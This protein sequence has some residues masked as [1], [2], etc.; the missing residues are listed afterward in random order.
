ML[1]H[2]RFAVALA[3]ALL[4]SLTLLAQAPAPAR[5]ATSS[6]GP[7]ASDGVSPRRASTFLVE[8]SSSRMCARGTTTGAVTPN[9]AYSGGS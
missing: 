1:P 9:A 4:I 8:A 2:R 5:W 3:A 7:H 6:K